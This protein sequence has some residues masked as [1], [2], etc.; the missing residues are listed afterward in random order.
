M[1]KVG[2]N[3]A[4]RTRRTL[5]TQSACWT[6]SQSALLCANTIFARRYEKASKWRRLFD[7]AE[8]AC[9]SSLRTLYPCTLDFFFFWR[10]KVSERELR[11]YH[12]SYSS[13]S[14]VIFSGP[15]TILIISF[16]RTIPLPVNVSH[17]AGTKCTSLFVVHIISVHARRI[18]VR[19]YVRTYEIDLTLCMYKHVVVW[20]QCDTIRTSDTPVSGTVLLGFSIPTLKSPPCPVSNKDGGVSDMFYLSLSHWM[21]SVC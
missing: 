10:S 3:P 6:P 4:H 18:P 1:L 9:V 21:P 13:R 15:A 16:L 14:L 11:T 2:S 5:S 12:V 19:T 8:L 20:M 7:A 17:T